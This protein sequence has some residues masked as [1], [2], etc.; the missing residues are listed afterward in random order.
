V[1]AWRQGLLTLVQCVPCR[2][3]VPCLSTKK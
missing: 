3:L 2:V 1:L